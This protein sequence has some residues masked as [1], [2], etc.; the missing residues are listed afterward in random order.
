MNQKASPSPPEIDPVAALEALIR[1]LRDEG[2][3]PSKVLVNPKFLTP[4]RRPAFEAECQRLGIVL[5]PAP[6]TDPNTLMKI[7]NQARN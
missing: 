4:E 7:M 1:K 2:G 5:E 3:V 6:I